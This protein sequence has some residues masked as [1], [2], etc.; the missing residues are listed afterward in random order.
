M[1]A[2]VLFEV[3]KKIRRDV[4]AFDARIAWLALCQGRVVPITHRTAPRA[5]LQGARFRPRAMDSLIYRVARDQGA[6][7][8]TRD[9]HFQGLP[10]VTNFAKSKSVG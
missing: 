1:P 4:G 2:V 9:A 5:A 10:G 7:L 8:V 6:E 3:Y